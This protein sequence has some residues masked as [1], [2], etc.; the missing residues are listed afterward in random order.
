MGVTMRKKT[1]CGKKVKEEKEGKRRRGRRRKRSEFNA[2][3]RYRGR[4]H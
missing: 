1:N 2:I 4:R 3:Q